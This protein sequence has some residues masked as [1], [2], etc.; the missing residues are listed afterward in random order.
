M[1]YHARERLF[2]SLGIRV[3][4]FI[5]NA[6]LWNTG[7]EFIGN[8]FLKTKMF[9]ANIRNV[10]S[11]SVRKTEMHDFAGNNFFKKEDALTALSSHSSSIH[12]ASTSAITTAT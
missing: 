10:N 4:S 12:F 6:F 3:A 2:Q 8:A 5:G 11:F 1:L 9:Y 7:C